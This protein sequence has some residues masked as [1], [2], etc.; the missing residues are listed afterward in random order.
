V[1]SI[2]TSVLA[3]KSLLVLLFLLVFGVY[4]IREAESSEFGIIGVSKTGCGGS[5]CHSPS[6]TASTVV[7]IATQSPQIVAGQTYDFTIVVKNANGIQKAA[8]CDI[9]VDGGAKLSTSG[10]G[11]QAANGELTHTQPRTF[12]SGD[13]ALWTFKYTAPTKAGTDHIY[14]GGNAVNLNGTND[15]GDL[16]NTTVYTV[17]VVQNSSVASD[18]QSTSGLR[19][20][21][22][23]SSGR[24]TIDAP[25]VSGPAAIE[26]VDNAGRIV[27]ERTEVQFNPSYSL[28]LQSLA[29]G[30]YFLWVRPRN[31]QPF[32]RMI[33]I[34][35]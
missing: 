16:W 34:E 32:E 9:S 35:K 31:A 7:T 33:S 30:T 22:N 23:P 19:V 6:R 25:Q 20:S 4:S 18:L 2:V 17:T 15:N 1:R 26:V 8:G 10:T 21:P 11:L 13:S 28:D 12:G 24:F 5:G 29:S 14:A 3:R 27:F